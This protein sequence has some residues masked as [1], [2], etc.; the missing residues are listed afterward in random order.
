M[1]E[2]VV[3]WLLAVLAAAAGCLDAVCLIRLGGVFASVITGNL[4]QLGRGIV[5]VDGR[6]AVAAAAAV[7]G[8][9]VGVAVGT[10]ALGGDAPGWRRRTTLVA[11]AE[12]VPA[13]G[14]QVGWV[15]SGGRAVGGNAWLLLALAG[16]AMGMQSTVT[17]SSGVRGAST[18][19]L[20]G[21]LTTLVRTVTGRRRF[22]AVRGDA[23]RLGALLLGAMVG[24]AMLR[25]APLWAPVVPVGLVCGVVVAAA[26]ARRR[27]ADAQ[28]P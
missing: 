4:V 14:V 8:Y 5:S 24:V 18:T 6:A 2:P 12:V 17:L 11:A 7:A 15:V 22:A 27:A 26:V 21:T 20:T 28:D 13:V 10:A 3:G 16:V 25:V 23:A 9:A 19:Y 1:P